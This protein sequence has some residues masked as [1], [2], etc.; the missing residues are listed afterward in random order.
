MLVEFG[1]CVLN[2]LFFVFVL[3]GGG[4]RGKIFL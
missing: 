4:G 2:Q 3:G 1:W